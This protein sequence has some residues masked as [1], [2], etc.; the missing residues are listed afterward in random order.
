[1]KGVS[2]GVPS[3]LLSDAFLVT[4]IDIV[5]NAGSSHLFISGG[6][7]FTQGEIKVVP[8]RSN[9]RGIAYHFFIKVS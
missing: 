2:A 4:I 5:A 3:G 9:C 8:H 7:I 6:I 1:M